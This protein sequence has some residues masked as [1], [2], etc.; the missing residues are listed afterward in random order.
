[1]TRLAFRA[2]ILSLCF[3][4]WQSPR[5]AAE[6]V[7]VG[8]PSLATALSPT[9]VTA[10]KGFWKKNGLDVELIYLSGAITI[11]SLLSGSV[12]VVVGSDT[13]AAIAMVKGSDIVRVGV[14]TNSLGSSLVTQQNVTSFGQLKGKAIGIGSRGFSSLELRLSQLLLENGIDPQHDV[15][16]LPLGGGPPARVAALEKGVIVAA[17]ITPPYDFVAGRAGLKIFAKVD[18]PLIAGGI[19]VMKPYLEKHRDVLV[20]FLKGYSEGIHFMLSHRAETIQIF[21]TYLNNHDKDILG[22]FYDEIAGRA[23]EDLRPDPRSVRFLLDFVGRR[24]P[25]AK[26]IGETAYTDLSLLDEIQRSGRSQGST[27]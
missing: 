2:V 12:Q 19:N 8:F 9:W 5:L 23:V 15:E 22:R 13:E 20:R 27:K 26:S 1:V 3:N 6:T 16:F 14:T 10:K 25:K 18:A 17:M 24:Y 7:R 21:S 11:P 4:L